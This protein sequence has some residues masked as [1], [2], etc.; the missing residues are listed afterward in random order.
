M[1]FEYN[2]FHSNSFSKYIQFMD[3]KNSTIYA[4]NMIIYQ[5][6]FELISKINHLLNTNKIDNLDENDDNYMEKGLNYLY[7]HTS[8]IIALLTVY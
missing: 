7:K 6:I 5:R 3:G 2:K 1:K 4:F 8:D